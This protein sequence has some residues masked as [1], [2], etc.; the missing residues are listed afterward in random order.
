MPQATRPGAV[1]ARHAR[2]ASL[3]A[4]ASNATSRLVAGDT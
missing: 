3:P 2:A 1:R 4:S